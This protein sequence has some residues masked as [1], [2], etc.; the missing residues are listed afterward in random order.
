MQRFAFLSAVVN[1]SPAGT[2]AE[3]ILRVDKIFEILEIH[4]PLADVDMEMRILGELSGVAAEAQ[5]LPRFVFSQRQHFAQ[6]HKAHDQ[7]SELPVRKSD[8][9]G[10]PA[11][12][13]IS[14]N[15]NFTVRGSV[16]R[17]PNGHDIV[18][19]QMM[20]GVESLLAELVPPFY[21]VPI[22]QRIL[23]LI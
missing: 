20:R 18:C 21:L 1:Q 13:K 2:L 11:F 14:D 8:M 16:H 10:V 22:F 5:N 19:S 4:F 3:K 12:R 6:M 23:H 17:R 15:E 7:R 9:N